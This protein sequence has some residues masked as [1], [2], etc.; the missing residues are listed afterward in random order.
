I[1]LTPAPVAAG[2]T[3]VIV[4]RP[5]VVVTGDEQAP[6]LLHGPE[7][8]HQEL[9]LLPLLQRLRIHLQLPRRAAR[10]RG[11]RRGVVASRQRSRSRHDGTPVSGCSG[12]EVARERPA[13]GGELTG[14]VIHLRACLLGAPAQLARQGRGAGGERGPIERL[15]E[16]EG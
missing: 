12:L 2:G 7:E 16:I 3:E 4:H 13:N 11:R 5:I 10:L 1:Y 8:P 9:H 15:A 14:S 6:L